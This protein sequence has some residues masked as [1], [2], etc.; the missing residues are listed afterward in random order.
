VAFYRDK[1]IT[2]ALFSNII[3]KFR[4]LLLLTRFSIILDKQV[5]YT[6]LVFQ[7]HYKY[8]ILGKWAP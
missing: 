1:K 8:A 5:T 4:Q 6:L 3:S 7:K 2:K